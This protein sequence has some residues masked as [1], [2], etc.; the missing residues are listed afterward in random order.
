MNIRNKRGR[1]RKL[2]PLIDD[3]R[4]QGATY[5]EIRSELELMH[6]ITFATARSCRAACIHASQW[7]RDNGD[8]TQS[9]KGLQKKGKE[10]AAV[11]TKE[12][13][14]FEKT[15]TEIKRERGRAAALPPVNYETY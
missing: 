1:L 6:G 3:W 7:V 15:A 12:V 8:K 5:N 10:S 4:A 14:G 13:N 2:V 9:A 11:V